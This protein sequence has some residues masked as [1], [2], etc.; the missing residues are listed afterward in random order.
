M[1]LIELLCVLAVI[2]TLAAILFPVFARAREAARKHDCLSNLVNIRFALE[3]Y[4][5]DHAGRF[6][7]TEDDLS[8]LLGRYLRTDLVFRCPSSNSLD[9]PMGA[10]ANPKLYQ[11]PRPTHHPREPGDAQPPAFD[12]PK[13]PL[14]TGYYY[15]AGH[16]PGEAPSRPV[17]SDQKLV[18]SDHANVLYTDGHAAILAEPAWRALGFKPLEEVWPPEPYRDRPPPGTGMMPGGMPGMGGPAGGPPGGPS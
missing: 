11:P 7:P 3:M 15:R 17:L 18:H 9:V 12:M 16:R 5:Q 1:T 8:P 10:P 6:P 2:A 4:A 14:P 13:V